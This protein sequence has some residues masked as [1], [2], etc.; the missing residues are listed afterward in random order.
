M[1]ERGLNTADKALVKA[2]GKRIGAALRNCRDR[3]LIA[4]ENGS[5]GFLIWSI[6]QPA[7][8]NPSNSGSGATA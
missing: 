1:G 3:G 6:K 5:G 2:M 4:S 8:S 7:A